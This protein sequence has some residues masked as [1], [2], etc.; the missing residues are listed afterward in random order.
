MTALREVWIRLAVDGRIVKTLTLVAALLASPSVSLADVFI[1]NLSSSPIWVARS[2]RDRTG[3][4]ITG[5]TKIDS[6]SQGQFGA[7]VALWVVGSG[8]VPK[9][10]GTPSTWAT[11]R[12][13]WYHPGAKLGL[14]QNFNGEIFVDGT[15]RAAAWMQRN[16]YQ[17]VRFVGWRDGTIV[18]FGN[19]GYP[20]NANAT[21]W[22]E[23]KETKRFS[24]STSGAK[25]Q[26]FQLDFARS[27]KLIHYQV[28][29][30]C[31][32]QA[33]SIDWGMGTTKVFFSAI[34]TRGW[35]QAS[36]CYKGTVD[37]FYVYPR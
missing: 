33:K 8:G 11:D 5:Y 23:G 19:A 12:P 6:G 9:T 25:S 18:R 21:A 29:I 27:H 24:H 17:H 2:T 20:N 28:N 35:N 16:G 32:R 10:P 3:F 1:R 34:L 30:S 37:L 36:P 14:R 13:M 26:Q 7:N 4:T 15:R 22:L 31:S